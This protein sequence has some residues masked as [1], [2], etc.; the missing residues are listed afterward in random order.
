[1]RHVEPD[2]MPFPP[3]PRTPKD[4]PLPPSGVKLVDTPRLPD[5]IGDLRPPRPMSQRRADEIAA[6]DRCLQNALTALHGCRDSVRHLEAEVEA[7]RD[8]PAVWWAQ[9]Q[10]LGDDLPDGSKEFDVHNRRQ[11][12]LQWAEA[13]YAFEMAQVAL[14]GARSDAAAAKAN[15]RVLRGQ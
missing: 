11:V 9:V 14:E 4:P 8:V 1:M 2:E 7:K 6:R 13:R 15:L 10:G 12:I 3:P 5:P